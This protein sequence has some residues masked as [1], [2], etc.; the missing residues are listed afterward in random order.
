[1]KMD[2][3]HEHEVG[4]ACQR[5]S[6]HGIEPWPGQIFERKDLLDPLVSACATWVVDEAGSRAAQVKAE[7]SLMRACKR[8]ARPRL[9][10]AAVE[11]FVGARRVDLRLRSVVV[12]PEDS[13]AGV[14]VWWRSKRGNVVRFGKCGLPFRVGHVEG[15]NVISRRVH[16]HAEATPFSPAQ[17][18][19]TAAVASLIVGLTIR[20][21]CSQVAVHNEG[22]WAHRV[23]ENLVIANR[24]DKRIF[25]FGEGVVVIEPD[26][27]P[28]VVRASGITAIAVDEL[29]LVFNGEICSSGPIGDRIIT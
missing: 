16:Y 8:R 28:V 4:E 15:V 20:T 2:G 29:S 9:G 19:Y 23:S 18:S 1:M 12:D 24:V 11:L 5:S 21:N 14:R 25:P 13:D 6:C 7:R 26:R 17:V 3:S 10:L 27:K 22:I